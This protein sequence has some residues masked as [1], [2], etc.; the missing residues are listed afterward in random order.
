MKTEQGYILHEGEQNGERFAVIATG[1]NKGSTNRKTGKMIQIYIIL[2][3]VHPVAAVQS[4]LDASTI[5]QDCPFASG[6]GCYV[7]VGQGV[8]SV[9]KSYR[10]GN[11]PHLLAKDF[12]KMFE[13][14]S[15][16]FGAYGNPT[17]LPL[18]KVKLIASVASGWTGYFHN[19][20]SMHKATAKA[21]NQYFMCSTETQDSYKL[22]KSLKMRVFHASPEKPEDAV[23]CVS[24][25]HGIQCIK[26]QLCQGWAKKA[27]NVWINPHGA[28]A[29]KAKAIAAA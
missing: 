3:D 16:R 22:A 24:D 27:K 9:W 10:A 1:F 29:G 20:H 14:R 19:W 17:L 6:N 28:K 25:S 11:Y 8:A 4:G 18:A 7:N 12:R 13:G 26:C 15:V 2:A 23:E 21:Y 5:C